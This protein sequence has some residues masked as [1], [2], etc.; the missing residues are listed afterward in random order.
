MA[1]LLPRGIFKLPAYIA[2][3]LVSIDAAIFVK[4]HYQNPSA[5]LHGMARHLVRFLLC[6]AALAASS[7]LEAFLLQ[8]VL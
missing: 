7:V 6:F 3:T 2:L 5:L 8:G 4:R 1:A